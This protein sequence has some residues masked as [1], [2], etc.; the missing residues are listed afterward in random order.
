[1]TIST[2]A[3]LAAMYVEFQF[4]ASAFAAGKIGPQFFATYHSALALVA[5]L[6]QLVV[7]PRL[8]VGRGLTPAL[9]ALP[10]GI[11]GGAGLVILTTTA[12]TQSVFRVL[13]NGAGSRCS[14]PLVVSSET[15]SKYSWTALSPAWPES[16]EPPFFMFWLHAPAD[17]TPPRPMGGSAGSLSDVPSSGLSSPWL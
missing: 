15:R 10:A 9:L 16:W 13:E 3:A 8:Q 5:L 2:L 1:M 17:T 7:A 6:L 14:Y 12:F 4:Y 11:L